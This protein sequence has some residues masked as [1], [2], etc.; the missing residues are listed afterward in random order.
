MTSLLD[1][2]QRLHKGQCCPVCGK[3]DWC[4]VELDTSGDPVAVLCQR[5]ESPRRW[6]DAG[7]LHTLNCDGRR[8]SAPTRRSGDDLPQTPVDFEHRLGRAQTRLETHHGTRVAADLGVSIAA[9]RTLGAGVEGRTLLAPMYDAD[10]AVVGVRTRNSNGAKRALRGSR[11]GLFGV[12]ALDGADRVYICEGLSDTA[13]ALMIGIQAIGR[14]SCRGGGHALEAL[15][16]SAQPRE[17][18][19][20]ADRDIP[21]RE[22]AWDLTTQLV[23]LPGLVVRLLE[24]PGA[25]KDLR[26]WVVSGACR[27][28][29]ERTALAVRAVPRAHMSGRAS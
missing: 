15:L 11:N 1:R 3:S 29:V 10:G 4:L 19:V 6:R 18:V 14:P 17:V 2:F 8:P 5:V 25:H 21:G 26:E 27:A 24:I 28:D 22:G 13:A 9:L 16:R 20:I 7:C 23:G 12:P